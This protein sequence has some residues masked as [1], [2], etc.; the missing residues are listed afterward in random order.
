MNSKLRIVVCCHKEC[1]VPNDDIFL[2]IHVGKAVSD[3]ELKFVGDDSGDNISSRNRLYCELTGLYWA[4]KN[5]DADYVGL[6]HYRRYYSFTNPKH[7]KTSFRYY[8]HKL[9]RTIHSFSSRIK[10]DSCYSSSFTIYNDVDLNNYLDRFKRDIYKYLDRNPE[11]KLFA[12]KPFYGGCVSN[13]KHFGIIAGNWH[14]DIL[15]DYIKDNYSQYYSCFCETLDANSLYY[16]NMIIARKDVL[17]NYCSFLFDT[18]NYHYNQCLSSGMYQSYDEKSL[19][20]LSGYLG[21]LITS[22]FVLHI[23]RTNPKCVKLLS[24]IQYE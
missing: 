23:K 14:V 24:Q 12:L 13:G 11:I 16:A 5:L 10:E 15:R 3:K 2:P 6:C 4:W 22:T 7:I 8:Y 21:E 9:S 18:L 1:A 19:S 20:R 17:S